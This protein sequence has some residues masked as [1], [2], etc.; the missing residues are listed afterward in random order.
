MNAHEKWR[1][2][3]EEKKKTE[4]VLKEVLKAYG[5]VLFIYILGVMICA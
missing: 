1:M 3:I 4:K 5:F 2:A